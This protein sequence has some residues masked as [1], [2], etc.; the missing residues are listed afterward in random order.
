M[1]RQ[2]S[3]KAVWIEQVLIRYERPLIRYAF[4]ITEDLDKARDVVQDTFLKLVKAD[5][6]KVESHLAAWLFTV[7]RNRALDIARKERRMGQLE[8]NETV[9]DRTAGPQETLQ[10]N[11]TLR[12]IFEALDTLSAEHKEAFCLKFQDQLN[13]REI[14]EIMGKSLCTVNKLITKALSTVQRHLMTHQREEG[15]R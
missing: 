4:R 6:Q 15:L 1:D 2:A 13:Y 11:E 5:R 8:N 9:P 3:D 12:H 7:T 14:G 10:S